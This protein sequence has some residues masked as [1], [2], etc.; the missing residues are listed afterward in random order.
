MVERVATSARG[1]PFR[2]ARTGEDEP[3]RFGD[4]VF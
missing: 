4:R 2:A 3:G 1:D